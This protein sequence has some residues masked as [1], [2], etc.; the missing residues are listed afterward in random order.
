MTG[1]SFNLNSKHVRRCPLHINLIC[2]W[3]CP[4]QQGCS[5]WYIKIYTNMIYCECLDT[6][7]GIKLRNSFRESPRRRNIIRTSTNYPSYVIIN[8]W[9][10]FQ[11][12]LQTCSEVSPPYKFGLFLGVSPPTRLFNLFY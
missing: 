7:H 1:A 5:I 8:D 2:F 9:C 3:G 11:S 4:L 6:Q 10:E 12:E